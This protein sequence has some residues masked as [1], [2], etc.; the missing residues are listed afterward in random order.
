MRRPEQR[1]YD[2]MRRNAPP[3]ALILRVENLVTPGT[4]DLHVKFQSAPTPVWIELKT[5][6]RPKRSSTPLL[7]RSDFT[8][9]QVPWHLQWHKYG[10][11]SFVL[12]RDDARTLYFFPGDLIRFVCEI[13]HL[14]TFAQFAQDS[15]EAFWFHLRRRMNA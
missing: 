5:T 2:T 10:G 12:V 6:N 11:E 8:R 3:D 9:E 1:L 15:W 7:K 13:P 14:D 4:P